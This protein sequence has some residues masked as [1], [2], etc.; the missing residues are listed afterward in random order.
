MTLAEALGPGEEGD[1]LREIAAGTA[2]EL[3]LTWLKAA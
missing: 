1:E 3:G 2:E